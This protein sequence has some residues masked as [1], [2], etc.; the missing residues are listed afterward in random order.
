MGTLEEFAAALP[1]EASVES[2]LLA[3]TP[4]PSSQGSKL[5]G[6]SSV[7]RLWRKARELLDKP[8][9]NMA[10]IQTRFRKP[11]QKGGANPKVIYFVSKALWV[12]QLMAGQHRKGM[13]G[14]QE[15]MKLPYV[16]LANSDTASQ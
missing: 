6:R 7:V 5:K 11:P 2:D 1:T 16:I 10:G 14:E 15:R 12:Q 9:A 13:F 8:S 3:A 4:F